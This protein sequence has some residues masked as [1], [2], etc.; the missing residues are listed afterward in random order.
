MPSPSHFLLSDNV[1]KL[2]SLVSA[3]LPSY[4]ADRTLGYDSPL[5]ERGARPFPFIFIPSIGKRRA[6]LTIV[7]SDKHR[8][9]FLDTGCARF[10]SRRDFLRRLRNDLHPL[11]GFRHAD[12]RRKLRYFLVIKIADEAFR[13]QAEN[14][15]VRL[16]TPKPPRI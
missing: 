11:S 8:T 13:T 15:G 12:R 7:W 10:I 6:P 1:R 2:T 9:Y 14:C 4:L 5:A 3:S 16:R